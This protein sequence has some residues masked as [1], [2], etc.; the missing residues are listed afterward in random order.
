ADDSVEVAGI[1]DNDG[2]IRVGSSSTLHLASAAT[3]RGAGVLV[4]DHAKVGCSIE[5]PQWGTVLNNQSGHTVRGSGMVRL[6]IHNAGLLQAADGLLEVQSSY[7]NTGTTRVGGGGD[8]RID[9]PLVE[10]IGG[11][12]I[13]SDGTFSVMCP[14]RVGG[15]IN[16]GL[17]PGDVQGQLV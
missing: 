5:V 14:F 15:S 8:I 17:R 2:T 6:P 4:L 9:N 1:F 13:G 10:N 12:I 11:R 7:F 3:F 16:N